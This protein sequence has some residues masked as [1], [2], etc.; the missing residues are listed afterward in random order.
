MVAL[1]GIPPTVGFA[2]KFFLFREAL[3]QG[4]TGLVVVG[5]VMSAISAYYY[6]RILVAMYFAKEE[7]DRPVP[8]VRFALA[9]VIFLCVAG[10]L[11]GGV[12]P[13]R[14]VEM[15]SASGFTPKTKTFSNVLIGP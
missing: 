10:T 6:L 5:V 15:S 3:N 12:A 14:A 11:Y 8:R 4:L 2:G 7:E 1:T 9:L 13:S